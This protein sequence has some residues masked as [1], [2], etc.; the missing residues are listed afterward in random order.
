MHAAWP[1]SSGVYTSIELLPQRS[2]W[3]RSKATVI[4]S[5]PKSKWHG[6]KSALPNTK[7]FLDLPGLDVGFSLVSLFRMGDFRK[8]MLSGELCSACFVLHW[9]WCKTASPGGS[10]LWTSIKTIHICWE[11]KAYILV[12]NSTS[13]CFAAP[14]ITGSKE[15]KLLSH[16]NLTFKP[17]QPFCLGE[18]SLAL[19]KVSPVMMHLMLC[20]SV[21]AKCTYSCHVTFFQA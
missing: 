11:I 9:S 5:L 8:N 2:C 20:I 19:N 17:Y 1:K 14:V 21:H 16:R 3:S 15:S 10:A 4:I 18:D 13:V 12:R 6:K 7:W